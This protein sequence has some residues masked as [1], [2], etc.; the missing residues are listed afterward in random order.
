[1]NQEPDDEDWDREPTYSEA[2]QKRKE[3]IAWLREGNNKD[4][5][6]LAKVLEQ[7][8]KGKRCGRDECPVCLRR[9][10]RVERRIGSVIELIYGSDTPSLQVRKILLESVK[11]TGK[12]RTLN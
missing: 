12:R 1:M 11:V 3:E 8:C 9:T 2:E 6:R 5:R 10:K 4:R 7:C